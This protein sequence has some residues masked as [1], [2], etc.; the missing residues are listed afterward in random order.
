MGKLFGTDGIR[1]VANRYPMTAEMALNVGRAV[2]T[3]FMKEGRKPRIIIGKDTRI[4]CTMLEYALVSG[5]CSMGGEAYLSGVLPTPAIAWLTSANGADAGIV[6]SASHNPYYDNGIKIFKHNGFKLSDEREAGIEKLLFDN[7][8]LATM[9]RSVRDTGHVHEMPAARNS[10]SQFLKTTLPATF[11]LRGMKIV[12]DC[13][14]GATYQVAPEIFT[15]LGADVT[16]LYVSPDGKNINAGC[17]S[18]HPETLAATVRETGADIGL[19][20]DGDGDRLIAVN[21]KGE[22]VTGDQILVIC[23]RYMKGQGTLRNNMA[24]STVMSNIGLRL[25]FRALGIDHRMADVGDRYVMKEMIASGGIIG[26][27][28]SGHMIFLDH[29]TTGDGILTALRLLEVMQAEE[30]PLSELAGIMEVFPQILLN[31]GVKHKP[32]ISS[33]PRIR[34]AIQAVEAALG[35]KGRVLVRYSGTQPLCRVM[36]EGPTEAET[37]RYCQQI[38]DVIEAELGQ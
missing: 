31:V 21:E 34:E 4:S 23:A 24:V 6:I 5:I 8:R 26:G 16:S 13:S 33:I 37:R 14:N 19:A 27:E 35:E 1:G 3:L 38:A 30:K 11:S 22:S 29:H 10:Y 32:E 7:D 2:A 18:Q 25:A 12:L 17:G 20:F 9:C 15:D 36:A 28:D